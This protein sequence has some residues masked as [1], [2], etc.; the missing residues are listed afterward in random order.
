MALA[1]THKSTLTYK[2]IATWALEFV[3]LSASIHSVSVAAA[4]L[5]PLS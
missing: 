2:T 4:D 3:C 5:L 1:N